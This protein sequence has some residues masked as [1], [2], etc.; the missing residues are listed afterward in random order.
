MKTSNIF[1]EMCEWF[2]DVEATN[3]IWLLRSSVKL[4]HCI[5]YKNDC[6]R[7]YDEITISQRIDTDDD[8]D[9]KKHEVEIV[10]NT[11]D[12]GVIKTVCIHVHN[13]GMV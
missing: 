2:W 13:I 10:H 1:D 6:I 3:N 4:K 8:N 7:D 5:C 9:N 12:N 11:E